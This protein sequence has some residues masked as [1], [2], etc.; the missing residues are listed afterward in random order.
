VS[1]SSTLTSNLNDAS[2]QCEAAGSSVLPS[3]V[4]IQAAP[5]ATCSPYKHM[6][7]FSEQIVKWLADFIQLLASDPDSKSD[8]DTSS[9][10]STSSSTSTAGGISLFDSFEVDNQFTLTTSIL[11]QA[12]IY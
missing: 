2:N 4:G 8:S 7:Q 12:V 6:N 5:P 1:F 9:S 10:A 11:S 3:D